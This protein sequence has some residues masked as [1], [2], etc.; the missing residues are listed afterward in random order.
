[1]PTS[2]KDGHVDGSVPGP[3]GHLS[4]TNASKFEKNFTTRLPAPGKAS[5]RAS[6]WPNCVSW[7]LV[8]CGVLVA[9]ARAPG[10]ETSGFGPPQSNWKDLKLS[11][12]L[13]TPALP[14]CQPGDDEPTAP[15]GE[16]K[17]SIAA[18]L[19]SIAIRGGERRQ[20]VNKSNRNLRR[21]TLAFLEDGTPFK[22]P[23]T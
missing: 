18:S 8:M 1:V 21:D 16:T 3:S 6:Y 4:K 19:G 7:P 5:S 2:E 10:E 15:S 14:R 20:H 17:V 23:K 13:S 22:P 12:K 11:S 9:L